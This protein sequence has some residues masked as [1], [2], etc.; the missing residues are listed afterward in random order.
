M[1]NKRKEEHSIKKKFA[2]AMIK[3]GK[4]TGSKIVK[5]KVK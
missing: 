3:V 4:K 5:V 1:A 2:E